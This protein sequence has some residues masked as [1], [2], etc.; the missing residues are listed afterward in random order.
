MLQGFHRTL[1]ESSLTAAVRLCLRHGGHLQDLIEAAK[2][3]FIREAE[4]Q[5]AR[6]S[7]KQTTSQLSLMTGLQRRDVRRVQELQELPPDEGD[8]PHPQGLLTRVIGQWQ[9]DRKYCIRPGEARQLTLGESGSPSPHPSFRD[10][11]CSISS[12]VNP[13]TVLKEL[14]RLKQVER[15]GDL[16][17]L[18]VRSYTPVANTEDSLRLFAEDNADLLDAVEENL[19]GA[20]SPRHL[21]AKTEFD[22]IGEEDVEALRGWLVQ[23]GMALHAKV[24]ERL[25]ALDRDLSSSGSTASRRF[26]VALGTF[27]LITP[28]SPN[29][30]NPEEDI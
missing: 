8:A 26:R 19:T 15:K 23:E 25:S 18:V 22:N 2:L 7:G 12:D 16:I 13:G 21:H 30:V 28:Y 10:L 20:A 17:R 24:R 1:L 11:V 6:E 14:L 29:L 5:L 27:S 3:V 9:Y 4:R